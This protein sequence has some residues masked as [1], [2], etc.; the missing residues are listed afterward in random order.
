MEVKPQ[1]RPLRQPIPSASGSAPAWAPLPAR[2]P[3]RESAQKS[4][5]GLAQGS[6][7]G[8]SFSRSALQRSWRPAHGAAVPAS[9]ER[10]FLGPPPPPPPP[11]GYPRLDGSANASPGPASRGEAPNPQALRP[12]VLHPQAAGARAEPIQ[13]VRRRTRPQVWPP[14]APPVRAV[15]VVRAWVCCRPALPPRDPPRDP[16][17]ALLLLAARRPQ[18]RLPSAS[19]PSARG[20]PRP[21]EGYPRQPHKPPQNLPAAE[22]VAY[23]GASW[24]RPTNRRARPRHLGYAGA[25]GRRV[26]VGG[27]RDHPGQRASASPEGCTEYSHA[28]GNPATTGA[29]PATRTVA[30]GCSSR[31]PP[32]RKTSAATSPRT[33]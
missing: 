2:P 13:P 12:E 28:P 22:P 6:A 25:L 7:R 5:Q 30:C 17:P 19:S 15:P 1:A 32:R 24:G 31:Y 27:Q 29:E 20:L 33:R 23:S 8:L 10:R 14:V 11:P 18:E 4:A 9:P 21:G 3:T 16:P 26:S